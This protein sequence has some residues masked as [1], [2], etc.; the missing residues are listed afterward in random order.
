MRIEREGRAGVEVADGEEEAGRKHRR[1]SRFSSNSKSRSNR[2]R[3]Y[4][5]GEAWGVET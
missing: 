1:L 5:G 2:R 4:E 3:K